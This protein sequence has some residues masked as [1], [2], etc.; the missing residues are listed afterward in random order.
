TWLFNFDQGSETNANADV[1]WDQMTD[2]ARQLVPRGNAQL[3]NLGAIDFD[4]LGAQA[5]M[6]YSYANVPIPASAHASNQLTPGDV[7]AVRTNAGNYA[8][9][10]V[11]TYGYNLDLRWVTY[12]PPTRWHPLLTE[13]GVPATVKTATTQP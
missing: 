1:W 10:Q 7:F 5:L 8:K 4:T 3:V 2:V 12:A 6:D 13:V 11:I 9:V